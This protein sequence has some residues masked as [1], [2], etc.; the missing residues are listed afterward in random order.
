MYFEIVI[1]WYKCKVLLLEYILK[2]ILF[3][4]N[5]KSSR[6]CQLKMYFILTALIHDKRIKL[7]IKSLLPYIYCDIIANF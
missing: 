5:P 1:M 3:V 4:I 7:I 2:L 6:I